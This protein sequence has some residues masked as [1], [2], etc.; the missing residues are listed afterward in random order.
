[1]DRENRNMK[2]YLVD[3]LFFGGMAMLGYGANRINYGLGW[4]LVGILTILY[5]RPL[6]GWL[7]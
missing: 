7:K 5:V 3:L 2:S 4:A 6:K 1:M